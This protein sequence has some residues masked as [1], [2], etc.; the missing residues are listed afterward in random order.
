MTL[1]Y[2]FADDADGVPTIW[3]ADDSPVANANQMAAEAW[4]LLVLGVLTEQS[5]PSP[6][7]GGRDA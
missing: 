6:T 7:S 3:R 5:R 2:Y 1:R 4:N